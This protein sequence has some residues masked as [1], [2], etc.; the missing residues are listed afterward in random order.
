MADLRKQLLKEKGASLLRHVG[1]ENKKNESEEN[2]QVEPWNDYFDEQMMIDGG[3]QVYKAGKTGPI[4]LF[5]HGAGHTS[6]SWAL[7]AVIYLL[8]FRISL[9][10]I[11]SNSVIHLYLF[12]QYSS[13]Y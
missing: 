11:T 7:V 2:F 1:L 4:C 5:I 9:S 3:F 13:L 12:W 10:L 8:N 6:L